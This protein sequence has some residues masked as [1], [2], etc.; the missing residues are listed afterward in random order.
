[1]YPHY[2]RKYGHG[3]ITVF[4]GIRWCLRLTLTYLVICWSLSIYFARV[5]IADPGIFAGFSPH[6]TMDISTNKPSNQL[7]FVKETIK[8]AES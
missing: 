7:F 1:M 5:H 3:L 8:T 6:P 4:H 2:I